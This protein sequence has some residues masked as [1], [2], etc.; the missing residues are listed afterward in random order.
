MMNPKEAAEA[1]KTV[2]RSYDETIEGNK[3]RAAA[4]LILERLGQEKTMEVF[5]VIARIHKHDGRISP[6]NRALLNQQVFDPDCLDHDTSPVFYAG[7]DH[8]HMA[9]V[10]NLFS[11]ILRIVGER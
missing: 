3:P 7:I 1:W 11:A 4:E 5:A 10:D 8:I 2:C 6:R 9:H